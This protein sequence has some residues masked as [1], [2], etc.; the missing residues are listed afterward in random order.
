MRAPTVEALSSQALWMTRNPRSATGQVRRDHQTSG[1][2]ANE[3]FLAPPMS[4]QTEAVGKF[5]YVVGS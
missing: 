5:S 3:E 1:A 4:T 2:V